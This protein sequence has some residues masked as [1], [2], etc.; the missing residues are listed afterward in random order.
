MEMLLGHAQFKL[1]LRSKHLRSSS[2]FKKMRSSPINKNNLVVFHLPYFIT[3]QVLLISSYITT[4]LDG[5]HTIPDGQE[6]LKLR[7]TQPSLAQVGDELATIIWFLALIFII[8]DY[9][10]IFLGLHSTHTE[11]SGHY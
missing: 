7:Q 4:F 11:R 9:K 5:L 8:T 10:G 6:K 1:A 3:N 2:C